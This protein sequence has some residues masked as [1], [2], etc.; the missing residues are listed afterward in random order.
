[1]LASNPEMT[2][3]IVFADYILQGC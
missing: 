3:A 1:V 2:F